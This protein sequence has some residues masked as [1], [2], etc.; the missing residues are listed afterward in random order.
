MVV[1][2]AA[3]ARGGA[4]FLRRG[5]GRTEGPGRG[6]KAEAIYQLA[7]DRLTLCIGPERP[8]GFRGAGP[9]ALV[10]LERVRPGDER[11]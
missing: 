6:Q 4:G 7:G 3:G 10:E 11:P 2:P 5:R 1:A 9:A 8:A